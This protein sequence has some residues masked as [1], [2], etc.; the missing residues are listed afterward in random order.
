MNSV[1]LANL[2][3][4][5]ILGGSMLFNSIA[6]K[7][8]DE[9]KETNK[10]DKESKYKDVHECAGLNTCKGLG[11]CKVT[12]E[13]LAKLSKAAGVSSDKAGSAHD[14]AGMNSCKGLGGCKVDN[15]KFAKLKS[16]ADK[17]AKEK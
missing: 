4:A 13:T 10:E 17:K 2:A 7:A 15:A 12:T 5:G 16:A 3:V 14:C 1:K 8:S 11:G 9:K 6:L